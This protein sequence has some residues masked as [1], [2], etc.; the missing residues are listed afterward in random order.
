M[1]PKD[2]LSEII[3]LKIFFNTTSSFKKFLNI[4]IIFYI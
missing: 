4:L 3:D 2:L 1:D